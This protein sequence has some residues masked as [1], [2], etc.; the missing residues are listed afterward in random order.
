MIMDAAVFV[1]IHDQIQTIA[2]SGKITGP[3]FARGNWQV[4]LY[5]VQPA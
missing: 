3:V 2:Y 1:P 4:R 5:N